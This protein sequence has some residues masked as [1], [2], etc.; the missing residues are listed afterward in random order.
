[1]LFK[2]NQTSENLFMLKKGMMVYYK[3][4]YQIEKKM[5]GISKNEEDYLFSNLKNKNKKVIKLA[6][7]GENEIFGEETI[8]G[9]NQKYFSTVICKSAKA[10]FYVFGKCVL[11]IFPKEV[12]RNIRLIYKEK[13]E[14]L[15]SQLLTLR[16]EMP[17]KRDNFKEMPVIEWL[18]INVILKHTSIDEKN[19][20]KMKAILRTLNIIEKLKGESRERRRRERM[21]GFNVLFRQNECVLKR[22]MCER[23]IS[24]AMTT[25]FKFGE[26]ARGITRKKGTQKLTD[27]TLKNWFVIKKIKTDRN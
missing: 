27:K 20:K 25:E 14:F 4:V 8:L 19:N 18:P 13:K 10:T 23:K 11:S 17:K 1:M 24:L 16:E 3:Q 6:D 7:S 26:M 15:K 21:E 2:E 5:E 12:L 22:Q 9:E